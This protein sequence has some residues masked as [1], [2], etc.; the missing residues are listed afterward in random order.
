MGD[1]MVKYF[2]SALI[3]SL[4]FWSC[5]KDQATVEKPQTQTISSTT[6]S[7]M[8]PGHPMTEQ[9]APATQMQNQGQAPQS[10]G[11]GQGQVLN[12]RHASG[13]TYMEVDYNGKKTWIA[14]TALKVNSGDKVMWKDAAVMNNF[15][16]K[17]LHKTFDEILFV[18][19]AAIAQ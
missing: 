13:Y 18:S 2:Y 5:D 19:H 9:A 4:F 15:Q 11:E 6:Q 3:F 10:L 17:T 1:T 16:S 14:S 8:P 7:A 12:V